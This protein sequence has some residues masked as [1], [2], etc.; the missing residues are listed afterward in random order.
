MKKLSIIITLSL[1]AL[2]LSAQQNDPLLSTLKGELQ[3][4]YEQLQ[5]QTVKPY[6]MSLRSEKSYTANVI[7][8]FGV[9]SLS[10]EKHQCTV[11][12]QVRVGD[13]TLDN[14]KYTTQGDPQQGRT[15]TVTTIPYDD[16]SSEGVR[17]NIWSATLNRY[18]L[19]TAIYEQTKS[20]ANT[21]VAAEDKA[22]CFSDTKVE[23]YYEEPIKGYEL[24]RAEWEK[25]LNEA[26][27]VFKEF[28]E[29][30][31]GTIT[32]T[33]GASRVYFV[34]TDGTEVV[35]NRVSARIM[36]S[37]SLTA[38]DG[39]DLPL[40]QDFFAYNLDSLPS[41][42]TLRDTARD[43]ISRLRILKD[44]PVANPYT[45][46][47][48]LSGPA[49]GVFFHEIFGH[50]LEGHRLKEGGETFKNMVGKS[51]LPKTF[52]V[53]SD[54]TLRHY[55]GTDLNGY[56]LYDSE[57]VKARRVQNVKD[58][59]LQ[60]FLMS[61]VPLDGF[62]VSN[63]HGRASSGC[64]PV[65][66]QSNLIVESTQTNTDAQLRQM[67]IAEAKKQ[68][69]EYG[70]YFKTVTSGYTLTGE[71]GSLNSFNVTPVEVYRI[72]VDG[73]ADEMVRGVDLIGTP[74]SMFSHI[75]AAGKDPSVFTGQCGAESGWVNVTASSP[76]IFVTQIETQ[77]RQKSQEIPP[78]LSAP[79]F[80]D[81]VQGTDDEVIIRAMKDEL[82]RST[83]SLYVAGAQ[84]PFYISYITNRYRNVNIVGELGGITKSTVTDW[85]TNISA[86]VVVGDFKRC[87]DLPNY[88]V[89][90]GAGANQTV[91]YS[92]LRR[93]FWGATNSA[94]IGAVN[95]YAQKVN[96]LQSNPLPGVLEKIPDM[97]RLAPVESIEQRERAFDIN[98]AQLTQYAKELSLLFKDY[99]KLLNTTVEI[100]GS[101][102]DTYRVTSENVVLKQPQD[103]VTLTVKVQYYT[104]NHVKIG[105]G[106]DIKLD[107]TADLPSLDELKAQ[108]RNFAD[109][110]MLVA[111]AP[112][113]DEYYKG[114]IMYTG[115]AAAYVFTQNLLVAGKF[116][117]KQDIKQD[118]KSLG[119]KIG[120]KVLDPNIT[121]KNYTNK[122]SYAGQRLIGRYTVDADGITAPEEMTI[123]EKGIF[124]MMLNRTTPAE[125]AEK[126]TASA[127][128][129]NSP[130]QV[131]PTVSVGTLHIQAASTT[132]EK[133][134]E[135]E[136][137]KLAKKQKLEY[138][139]IIDNPVNCQSLCLYRINVKTGEKTIVVTNAMALPTISQLEKILAVSAQENVMN[140]NDQT[141]QSVIY[142]ASIILD[143]ME[144]DRA[145][146]KADKA[147][148]IKYPLDR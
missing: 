81:N 72:Y 17:T 45:G 48:I 102:L 43:L 113:M 83:D 35:Q 97:Q 61:R 6:Y 115:Q 87:S 90:V 114:P 10:N 142:P 144:L 138:A 120:K 31:D 74:L 98:E 57:G 44:A 131:M 69:K 106:M 127:R 32:L 126:S 122:D 15:P 111:N 34:N 75:A 4:D 59:I 5:K 40:M 80:T 141:N 73:R 107:N 47:A 119:Q 62:P 123:V 38:A 21:S 94:Y 7:S 133:N 112:E 50:R 103:K 93:A 37:A 77:R 100:N 89:M 140:I 27:A 53:F 143:G 134:M 58:G 46:P 20:K 129:T 49:S 110:C 39:M 67:L 11:V 52:N 25:R 24:N 95:S 55:A 104:A 63:G 13:K 65:S 92:S 85:N 51:V 130:N 145:T 60:E 1:S 42:N 70:Y 147:E 99:P 118:S 2:S 56:Y 132:A 88:P 84:R 124:K 105:D 26:S 125:F 79:A 78:L 117:A 19:A 128:F 121:I 135:K 101:E 137:I 9:T 54:P 116:Y 22:P 16:F 68:G 3:Y 139:Y 148:V 96:Y 33:Y 76:S 64:D 23:K 36:L 8:S 109:K 30:K 14:F 18:N 12:P 82:K 136:L 71:G 28:P 66:R 41:V 29:L 86:H 146:M 91:N 108:V